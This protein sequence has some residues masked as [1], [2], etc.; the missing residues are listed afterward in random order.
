MNNHAFIAWRFMLK[1]IGRVRISAMT[2][3]AW[4]AIGVGIA[5]MSS[6]LSVMYGFEGALK[7]RVLKAYPHLMVKPETGGP[8]SGFSAWTKRF[9]KLPGVQRVVEYVDTEM[10]VQ[11]PMRTLGAVVWGIS[12][13]EIL[14]FDEKIR[15]G[16]LLSFDSLAPQVIVGSEL[17]GRLGLSSGSS[18]RLI[19]PLEKTGAFGL[20]PR[21][22]TFEVAGIFQTGHYEFDQQYVIMLL[23]DA[24][25]L[26]RWKN[27]ISGWHIWGQDFDQ[28]E[29][30]QKE[31][32]KILP[33][34]LLSQSWTSFNSA[35]FQSLKLEQYAM[36]LILSF[37][38]VIAV[39]NI[40]ITLMMNVT[41]KR[42]HIGVLRALGASK[43]QIRKIFVW[44]G[45]WLGGVGMSIGAIL[46]TS[47]ILYIRYFS[48]Y[49]L[50]EIYYDRSIPV[51]IRPLSL[52]VIYLTAATL[53]Y[54]GTLYPSAK[55]ASLHPIEAIRE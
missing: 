40:V 39:M 42:V 7:E 28:A 55:A 34:Q 13:S 25:N 50:P 22:Q 20:A 14:K 10:I 17:A 48:N 47:F 15:E 52:L 37:A 29:A 16:K 19:S 33:P 38:I 2:L 26:L 44:Q 18:L 30:L 24:Q 53:I 11:S 46:T 23:E 27:A 51:E 8:L 49:Q 5:A 21:Q 1:G 45:I 54:L 35:L 31:I 43:K 12:R 9:E 36:F 4:L 32:S 3:F 41:H 6:L